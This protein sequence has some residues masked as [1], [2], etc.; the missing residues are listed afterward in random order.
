MAN[1]D[2][3]IETISSMTV[4]ELSRVGEG[5]GGQIRR[6]RIGADDGSADDGRRPGGGSG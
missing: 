1:I 2:E 5:F 4:L 3:M 6:E